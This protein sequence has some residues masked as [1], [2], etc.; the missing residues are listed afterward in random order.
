[1][2]GAFTP[3]I[4]NDWEV[5]FTHSYP[6]SDDLSEESEWQGVGEDLWPLKILS[7]RI[8]SDDQMVSV[9]STL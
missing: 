9:S 2:F 4:A 1:M 6:P 3:R 8:L 5:R 7:W